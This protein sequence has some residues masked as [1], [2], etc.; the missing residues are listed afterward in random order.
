MMN[1]ST[2]GDPVGDDRIDRRDFFALTGRYGATATILGIAGVS[3]GATLLEATAAHAA[4]EEDKKAAAEHVLV[5]ASTGTLNRWPDGSV[6][7]HQSNMTGFVQWKDYV[8]TF[9]GGK[10]YV[11]VHFGGAL[12]GQIATARKVQQGSLQGCHS[13]SQNMAA[14]APVWN[15][16]DF[17]YQIG[18][19]ENF[20]KICYSK[21]V[22]DTLRET[23]KQQGV[24]VSML[25]P[26]VRWIELR[27]GLDREVRLPQ[28]VD[29]LKIR[30]TGSKLEQTAFQI[31]PANPTPVAWPEVYNALKDGAVD[32]IHVA[33]GP[34][35]DA[36]ISEVIGSLVDTEFFY[37]TDSWWVSTK[38][39]MSLPPA[40]QEALDRASYHS[41]I[42]AH[43]LYEPLLRHQVGIRPDS[44][45]T[46]VWQQ[47]PAKQILLSDDERAQWQ[48]YLSYER[49][50]DTYDPLIERFGREVYET[51]KRVA[52][53]PGTP[54]QKRWW[55]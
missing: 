29:G 35:A 39:Y 37:N 46:A 38:W 19:V 24:I 8:E 17:P 48:E 16:V 43:D 36:K 33:P 23:S 7:K 34:V 52:H 47:E 28:D 13:S 42:F 20:W 9:S 32:G 6:S 31:L 26:M 44:P 25:F 11:D 1:G 15:A 14:V 49:N 5:M 22:N 45:P 54:E 21:E 10:I 40:L 12:G 53:E 50:K 27:Q 55:T 4:S 18:P 30:V 3:G 41:Q 51:V 2:P